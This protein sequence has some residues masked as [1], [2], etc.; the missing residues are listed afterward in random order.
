LGSPTGIDLLGEDGGSIPT[1]E[2]L[3]KRHGKKWRSSQVV[4]LGIGQGE[5]LLTPLQ[6]ANV[7]AIIANR[8]FY[9]TPHLVKSIQ[10]YSDTAWLRKFTKK[11]RT[12]INPKHFETIIQG[13]SN[14]MKP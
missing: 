12:T 1:V 5:I 10:G 13:M 9:V 11:R 4:S 3:A 8:G 2:G 6:L 14:V 7:A